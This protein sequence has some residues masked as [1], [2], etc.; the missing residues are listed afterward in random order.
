M[1]RPRPFPSG[2]RHSRLYV[3]KMQITRLKIPGKCHVRHVARLT[4]LSVCSLVYS[5]LR[6]RTF[7]Q[8]TRA[9]WDTL[10]AVNGSSLAICCGV[11]LMI[12]SGPR[13]DAPRKPRGSHGPYASCDDG[14]TAKFSDQ[15]I[16]FT[17][18]GQPIKKMV[19][20]LAALQAGG[21]GKVGKST[22]AAHWPL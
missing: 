22:F 19:V 3:R 13:A 14:L 20:I 7:G 18:N 9:V 6:S 11:W 8:S 21:L 10:V 12:V 4:Q 5:V 2:E 15:P 1:S 16:I 17:F